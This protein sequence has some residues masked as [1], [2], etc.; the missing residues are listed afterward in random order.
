MNINNK[1]VKK[2]FESEKSILGHCLGP[3]YQR[4]FGTMTYG[5]IHK[6]NDDI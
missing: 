6:L 4:T 3:A 5:K 1:R 2:N